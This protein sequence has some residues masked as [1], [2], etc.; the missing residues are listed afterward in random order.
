MKKARRRITRIVGDGIYE[1]GR[2]VAAGRYRSQGSP[3][4]CYWGI[5]ADP[6]GDNIIS[7]D[8]GYGAMIVDVPE[9]RFFEVSGCTFTK[10]S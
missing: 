1:V 4:G 3:D 7:N 6:N 8:F 9:G 2:D 5:N 10:D